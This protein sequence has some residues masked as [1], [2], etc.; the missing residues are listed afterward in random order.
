MKSCIKIVL[1]FLSFS[2]VSCTYSEEKIDASD[3]DNLIGAWV[4]PE[5]NGNIISFEKTTSLIANDYGIS[6]QAENVFIERHSGF[7]GTPP[8]SFQD[9]IG[10]WEVKE[11]SVS[12]NIDMG[13]NGIETK[14]WKI[15]LL[16]ENVLKL[17][18]LK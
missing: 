4:N 5:Y 7:C 8:L 6:F 16:Q 1:L 18:L 2:F 17:E 11:G 15:I 14:Q 3:I 9:D 12:I 13:F 10:T